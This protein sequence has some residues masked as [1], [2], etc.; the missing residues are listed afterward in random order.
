MTTHTPLTR[1]KLLTPWSRSGATIDVHTKADIRALRDSLTVRQISGDIAAD[2]DADALISNITRVGRR[3]R[4]LDGVS[5]TDSK[6][7]LERREEHYRNRLHKPTNPLPADLFQQ[8]YRGSYRRASVHVTLTVNPAD[9]EPTLT[10]KVHGTAVGTDT[11]YADLYAR[12][13]LAKELLAH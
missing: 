13:A 7:N 1:T 2:F 9:Q 6:A 5:V 10:V 8:D 11:D 12:R 4:L 3:L